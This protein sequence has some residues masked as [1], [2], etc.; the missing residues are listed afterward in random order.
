ML[1][2]GLALERRCVGLP[3]TFLI[4]DDGRG[5]DYLDALLV[6]YTVLGDLQVQLSHTG[7][8]VLPRL[9]VDL[10]VEGRVRLGDRPK[11][12]HQ[13]REVLH[14]LRLDGL[15]YDG[16]R[17]VGH[18]LEGENVLICGYSGTRYRVLEAGDCNYVSRI[19]DLN[20]NTVGAHR[21]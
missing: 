3:D 21:E 13:F 11:N 19:A 20:G 9:I 1:V 7:Q 2:G 10:D 16:F 18:L 15:R 8:Q 4:N 6:G 5:C 17:I 14:V 12:L